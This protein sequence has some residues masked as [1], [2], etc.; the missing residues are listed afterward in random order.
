MNIETIAKRIRKR[1]SILAVDQKTVAE[2]S[3][4][5][6]HTLSD[7]ESAKGNPS[8]KTICRIPDTI[9]LD[10][11]IELKHPGGDL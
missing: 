3:G 8:I 5:S 10:M 4:V 9:G 6:I 1:R 7:I 2:L 11:R